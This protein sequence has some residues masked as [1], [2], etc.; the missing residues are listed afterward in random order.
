[1]IVAGNSEKASRHYAGVMPRLMA[2]CIDAAVLFPLALGVLWFDNRF[3]NVN[4]YP[5]ELLFLDEYTSFRMFFCLTA[6]ILI[7]VLY[8]SLLHASRLQASLGKLAVGIHITNLRGQR[9][10]MARSIERSF[11]SLLSIMLG[12]GGYMLIMLTVNRTALHDWIAGSIVVHGRPR[13]Q[14]K[15]DKQDQF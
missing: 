11:A 5:H 15:Q 9:I 3:L 7:Y 1:M 4:Q 2:G 10:S 13:L 6:F 12:F 14:V 8:F